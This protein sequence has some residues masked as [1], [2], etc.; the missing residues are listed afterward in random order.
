MGIIQRWFL[1][2]LLFSIGLKGQVEPIQ[3]SSIASTRIWVV[4]LPFSLAQ[5]SVKILGDEA[6]VAHNRMATQ[7]YT[8]FRA[9]VDSLNEA[10]AHIELV[11]V[12][13]DEYNDTY[14][15]QRSG[16]GSGDFLQAYDVS[17]F[18]QKCEQIGAEKI[19]GPFRGSSS[20]RLSE[21]STTIPVINPV[22]RT[23]EVGNRPW[24]WAAASERMAEVQVLGQRAAVAKSRAPQSKTILLQDA[25]GSDEAFLD[26]YVQAGGKSTDLILLDPTI[27]GFSF[28]LYHASSNF[29]R[30][31]SLSEK[32]LT[33]AKILSTMRGF[34]AKRVEFWTVGQSITSSA[35]DAQLL[36]RQ[37]V[38]W[39]QVERLDYIQFKTLDA[40][41]YAEAKTTPGR[42]EWLGLDMAWF[43][44][45]A[46]DHKPLAFEGPRRVYLWHHP[47]KGGYVNHAA[48]VFRYDQKGG[49][50]PQWTPSVDYA[51]D[52]M[53]GS[54]PILEENKRLGVPIDS[55]IQK[56]R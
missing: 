4:A 19:I 3:D 38:V 21:E 32:V 22:S 47:E 24:L 2:A 37:P 34:D 55:I 45:Y 16:D 35:L 30:V 29:I 42:W 43:A 6:Y 18:M 10:G 44:H 7:F 40:L 39:A 36:M 48:L 1:L 9:G 49:I 17:S 15:W 41:L 46:L 28:T 20:E 52:E 33:T 25:S 26:A 31:V 14:L 5:D 54:E 8:G 12:A 50:Q 51:V 13:H 23:I 11:L 53:I 56:P 27:P